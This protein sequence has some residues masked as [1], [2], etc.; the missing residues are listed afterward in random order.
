MST[1]NLH[2]MYAGH[3]VSLK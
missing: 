1:Q 3:R 2:D